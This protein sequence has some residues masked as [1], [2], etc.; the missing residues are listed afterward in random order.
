M[1][2]I[3]VTDTGTR[4]RARGWALDPN[5]LLDGAGLY[6]PPGGQLEGQ[7]M[8]AVNAAPDVVAVAGGSDVT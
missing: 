2:S 6:K 1:P 3:G 4:A 7:A 8:R 5:G